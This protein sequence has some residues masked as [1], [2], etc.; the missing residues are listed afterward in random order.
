MQ[1]PAIPVDEA[2]R[3]S[4]LHDLNLL[5]TPSEDR[6]DRLTRISQRLFKV[7]MALISLIDSDRQWFKSAAGLNISETPRSVSFCGHTIL[8]QQIFIVNDT[9]LDHRFAD[10]PL[11]TNAPHIRFY[12]GRPLIAANGQSGLTPGAG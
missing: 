5:D 11:V 8:E 12:A 4:T 9:H 10:N 3:I 2:F 6:F 7:P 1:E